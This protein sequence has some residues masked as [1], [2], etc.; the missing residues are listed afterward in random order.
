MDFAAPKFLEQSKKEKWIGGVPIPRWEDMYEPQD[1]RKKSHFLRSGFA[2]VH[3]LI[4]RGTAF[5]SLVFDVAL[6]RFNSGQQI[7]YLEIRR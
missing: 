2:D 6:G 7:A 3:F 4:L 1:R 5:P